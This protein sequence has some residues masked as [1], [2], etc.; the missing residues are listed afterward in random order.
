M[1]I[2]TFERINGLNAGF[3]DYIIKQAHISIRGYAPKFFDLKK[4]IQMWY[5]KIIGHCMEKKVE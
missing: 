2:P 4:G 5:F 3:F 1:I